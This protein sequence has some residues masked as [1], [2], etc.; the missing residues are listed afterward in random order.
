M[1]KTDFLKSVLDEAI[2]LKKHLTKEEVKKISNVIID[3]TSPTKCIYGAAAGRCDSERA[4][5]LLKLCAQPF[6]QN[7]GI[8]NPIAF[9]HKNKKQFIRDDFFIEDLSAVEVYIVHCNSFCLNDL[10][11]F[12]TSAKKAVPVLDDTIVLPGVKFS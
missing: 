9:S 3:G 8:H 10:I 12:L 6:A 7:L 11:L 1:K 5:E 4:I 2:A